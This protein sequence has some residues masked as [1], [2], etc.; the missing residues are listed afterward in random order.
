[1]RRLAA[2]LFLAFLAPLAAHATPPAEIYCIQ[3][4]STPCSS[5]TQVGN[6]TQGDAGYHIFGKLNDWGLQLG[7]FSNQASNEFLATPNGTAG[8]P[9][10][11]IIVLADLPPINLSLT[12][13]N[14]GVTG[15]LGYANGGT[16]LTTLTANDCLAANASANGYVFVACG[17]GGS[18]TWPSASGI[19]CYS[20]SSSWCTSYTASNPIPDNYLSGLPGS[21][22][23]GQYWGYN[24]SSQG[25]YTPSGSGTVGSCGTAGYFAYYSA[26]GTT[27]GCQSPAAFQA[28]L[29]SSNAQTY[30]PTLGSGATND[31][32][33]SGGTGITTVGLVNA[34][35]NASGSTVDGVLAGSDKQQF[36]LCN[37]A[38]L[39]TSAEYIILE[40]QDS[41]DSTATNRLSM[42]GNVA[43]GP[44]MCAMFTYAAGSVNR[45]L[46]SAIANGGTPSVLSLT[47]S[48]SMTPDCSFAIATETASTSGTFTINAPTDCTPQDGQKLQI[49][50]LSASGGA[51][52][53][54]W[55]A[56]YIASATLAIPTTANAASKEDRFIFQWSATASAWVLLAY[57]Q[58]YTL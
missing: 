1:M 38:A 39:G 51:A 48:T 15:T 5:S 12:G 26:A 50:I 34:T 45:W 42:A 53:Y 52:A 11:R 29:I 25:W 32:D 33:P 37:T 49:N 56:T 4:S 17:G 19:P 8:I 3:S 54:S 57:N 24:G 16:G 40:N 30:A 44:Q 27:V 7:L 23:S 28:A 14:G 31:W 18:M 20:G 10:L 46:V 55:N 43:L 21:P 35:P 9:S 6:G 22:T 41:S 36:I 47:S 2:L 13:S 58:G